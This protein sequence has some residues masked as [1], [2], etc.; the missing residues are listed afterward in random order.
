MTS[1]AKIFVTA[2]EAAAMLSIGE[3]TF[4]RK[5]HQGALPQAVKLAGITRWRVEDLQRCAE[6]QASPPTTASSGASA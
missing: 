6:P 2:K 4:W 5:V 1:T 3:S